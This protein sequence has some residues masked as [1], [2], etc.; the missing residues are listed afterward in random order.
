MGGYRRES[1]PRSDE[2][3]VKEVIERGKMHHALGIKSEWWQPEFATFDDLHAAAV[4]LQVE[5]LE[6]Y[7]SL[8]RVQHELALDPADR[9]TTDERQN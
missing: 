2:V 4:R 1:D 9:P 5:A 3:I 6:D 8:Y 7:W